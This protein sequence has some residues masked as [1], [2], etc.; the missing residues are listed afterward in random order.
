[1][2]RYVNSEDLIRLPK[3]RR[4]MFQ[5]R[6]AQFADRH[7]WN[8]AVDQ[9]GEEHDQYDVPEATYVVWE[10]R[11]GSHGGSMRFLPTLGRTMVEEH[12]S[13]LIGGI[14]YR[15][16]RIWECTRFCLSPRSPSNIAPALMLGGLEFCLS[17]GISK[18]IGVFD[19]RMLRVYRR[20]GWSPDVLGAEGSEKDAISAGIWTVD[21]M[22]RP[23]LLQRA[24]VSSE[25]SSSWIE[26]NFQPA[27][28]RAT[29]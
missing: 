17:L 4:T 16:A 3:L 2:L 12:F 29:A 23:V 28:A 10:N 20:L 15:S 19:A 8:V 24:G 5:D 25:T 21:R 13:G 9:L 7:G 14:S 1:M 27:L 6:A 22:V 18:V 26:E 11:D